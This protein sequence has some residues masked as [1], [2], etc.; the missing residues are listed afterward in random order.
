MT[1][2]RV[3]GA[4]VR[5]TGG[6]RTRRIP[7][8]IGAVAAVLAAR[9]AAGLPAGRGTYRLASSRSRPPFCAS[10]SRPP[11]GWRRSRSCWAGTAPELPA[12][13][14]LCGLT[15]GLWFVLRRTGAASRFLAAAMAGLGLAGA[16]APALLGSFSGAAALAAGPLPAACRRFLGGG[17]SSGRPPRRWC[18]ATGI[19]WTPRFPSG[20][21][22]SAPRSFS[23]ERRSGCWSRVSRSLSGAPRRS[24]SRRRG[25]LIY[26]TTALFFSFRAITGLAAPLVLAWLV[27]STVRIRSTQS[28]TGLLYV[29]LILVLF[30]ELTAV[31]LEGITNGALA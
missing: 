5:R 27:R 24:G 21:W 22:P 28:A 17:A 9:L 14:A 11:P 7:A 20:R 2:P 1:P 13:A 16:I 3:G 15:L 4:F 31:F 26:S 25:D 8:V 6:M 23:A 19:W 10:C 30:G 18:S 29:A 12:W